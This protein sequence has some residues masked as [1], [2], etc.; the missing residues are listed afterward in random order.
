[1]PRHGWLR[2]NRYR[3]APPAPAQSHAALSPTRG[4]RLHAALAALRLEAPLC[5]CASAV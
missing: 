2:R 5:E 3:A 1:M 4:F